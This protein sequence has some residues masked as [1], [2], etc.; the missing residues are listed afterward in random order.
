MKTWTNPSVEELEVKM[1][2]WLE[3]IEKDEIEINGKIEPDRIPGG[4]DA[5]TNEDGFGK[6]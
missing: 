3:R 6:S 5:E 4:A 1:T 2:A